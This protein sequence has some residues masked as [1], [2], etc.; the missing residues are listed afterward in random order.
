KFDIQSF[1]G[2]ATGELIKN[3]SDKVK[4]IFLVCGKIEKNVKS[5][6]PENVICFQLLDYYRNENEAIE[7]ANE[8]LKV[9]AQKIIAD[10]LT[11]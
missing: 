8:G 11:Q 4:K 5:L 1:E 3:F 6:L 9:I 10:H 2:K 7:K